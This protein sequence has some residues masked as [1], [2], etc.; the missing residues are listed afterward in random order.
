MEPLKYYNTQ[1]RAAHEENTKSYF[2]ALLSQ[3]RVDVEAN[4][5]TVKEYKKEL[6]AIEKLDRLILKFKVFRVLFILLAIVG[7]AL[8]IPGVLNF[9]DGAMGLGALFCGLGAGLIVLGIL[10]V[11]KWVNPILK[12]AGSLREKRVAKAN[13]LLDEAWAQMAPLNA[14]FDDVDTFRIIEKTVP[15]FKFHRTFTSAHERML[16]KNYDF[17]DLQTDDCSMVDAIA[18]SFV[19]NPFCICRRRIHTLGTKTYHGTLTISWT[20]SYRDSNGKVQTRTRTQTLHAQ[21]TKP[22]PYYRDDTFLAYGH[23]AAPDLTF[24]R[25]PQHSEDLS[26]KALDRRIKRGEKKIEKLGD[27]AIRQGGS[28]QEMSN[29]E[30]D[31]LFGALNR[32]HE[33]QFRLMYTPLAQTNTVDL[34][35]DKENFGDDFHFIKR[36]RFNIIKSEHTQR[37]SLSTSPDNY[38]SYDVDLAR[39][40]FITHNT[41]YFKG[42]FFDFAPLMSVPAYV[43]EPISSLEDIGE[44][45]CNLGYY[46]HEVMANARGERAFAHPDTRTSVI[47]KTESVGMQDNSDLV[48]VRAYSYATVGRVEFIPVLGGDGRMHAVPVPW[49]EYIPLVSEGSM[50]V[51]STGLTEREYKD[52]LSQGTIPT[53]GGGTFFRSLISF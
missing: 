30:F 36:K 50:S 39:E 3:S 11:V 6:S 10:L 23:Q 13:E 4:R 33:V 15:E 46:S 24:S 43:E 48:K 1:G 53:W 27:K 2:D 26:E 28:F 38:V 41:A 51:I 35:C 8:F 17:F 14:L 7:G 40:R 9:L 16:R 52:A 34:L 29:S 49:T 47:L 22:M 44:D 32:N 42:F 19:G 25:E 12:N 37:A 21:V 20:E 31:V 18:G 5:A 45:V